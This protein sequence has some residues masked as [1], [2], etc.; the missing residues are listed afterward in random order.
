MKPG[1][2]PTAIR[3][4]KFAAIPLVA[5]AIGVAVA[6]ASSPS[7]LSRQHA[8]G[9]PV[10]ASP[11]V[12]PVTETPLP[13]VTEPGILG[14]GPQ[15]VAAGAQSLAGGTVN[16]AVGSADG[17]KTWTTLVPPAKASGIV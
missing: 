9:P 14:K 13:S 6:V 8:I 3:W 16:K 12:T 17:G 15:L 2:P 5:L 4:M 11:T 10:P 7:S 1:L